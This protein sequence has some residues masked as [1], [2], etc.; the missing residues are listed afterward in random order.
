[1]IKD[2]LSN[3]GAIVEAT[4]SGAALPNPYQLTA[5]PITKLKNGYAVTYGSADNIDYGAR[6]STTLNRQI[7]VILTKQFSSVDLSAA[8]RQSAESSFI[9]LARA[10]TKS[11][12]QD[13]TLAADSSIVDIYYTNDSGI[14]LLEAEKMTVLITTIS[15][16]VIYN[17]IY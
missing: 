5:N 6:F 10:V 4:T 13:P 17:E 1:M 8:S 9:D 12:R 3:I 14:E 7:D 16:R 11:I 15:F 2:I